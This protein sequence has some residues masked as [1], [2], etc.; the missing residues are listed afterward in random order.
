MSAAGPID[1]PEGFAWMAPLSDEEL[2][3]VVYSHPGEELDDGDWY[4]DATSPKRGPVLALEGEQRAGGRRVHPQEQGGRAA[5]GPA[6]AG[7]QRQA[8]GGSRWRL[9]GAPD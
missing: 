4:V 9:Y 6:P 3:A 2:A 7:R 5:L 8:L 1:A